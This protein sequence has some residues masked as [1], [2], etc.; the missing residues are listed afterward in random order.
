LARREK[1]ASPPHLRQTTGDG[2]GHS[3]NLIYGGC[4]STKAKQLNLDSL[5][6]AV[7]LGRFPAVSA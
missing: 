7:D 5:L 2:G 4:K 3:S 1:R 6:Q